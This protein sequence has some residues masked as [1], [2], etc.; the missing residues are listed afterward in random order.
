MMVVVLATSSVTE[1]LR[2]E[3][4]G[5]RAHRVPATSA[6][7][8]QGHLAEQG[9]CA[10]RQGGAGAGDT[11]ATPSSP[12]GF[13]QLP[14]DR[15]RPDVIARTMPLWPYSPRGVDISDIPAP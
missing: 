11:D 7:P 5:T 8:R 15:E 14:W 2:R 1:P 6:R 9:T 4:P 10:W 12:C 3:Q 13:T